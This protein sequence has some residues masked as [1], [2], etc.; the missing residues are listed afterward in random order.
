MSYLRMDGICLLLTCGCIPFVEGSLG[1]ESRKLSSLFAVPLALLLATRALLA[2][3]APCRP[4]D[5]IAAVGDVA[6]GTGIGAGDGAGAGV[7][8]GASEV[9]SYAGR[10]DD[11]PALAGIA[12]AAAIP[13]TAPSNFPP[14]AAVPPL[15]VLAGRVRAGRSTTR[16]ANLPGLA[17]RGSRSAVQCLSAPVSLSASEHPQ[18]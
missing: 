12:G 6:N 1:N 11:P 18:S 7:R 17:A 14:A 10:Q 15:P 9:E 8:A 5:A 13:C 2:A 16:D 4:N 3:R